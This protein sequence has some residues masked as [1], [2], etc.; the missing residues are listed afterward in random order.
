MASDNATVGTDNIQQ[1][2]G[3]DTLVILNSATVSSDD[4]FNG[5]NGNDTIQLGDTIGGTF[6]LSTASVAAGAGFLSYER[7]KFQVATAPQT[8]IFNSAQFG[9]GRISSSAVFIGNAATT[10]V[11]INMATGDTTFSAAAFTF[12]TWTSGTD[13]FTINGSDGNNTIA[14]TNAVRSIV[15]AGLGNDTITT[16]GSNDSVD[17]G[18]GNDS[19]V[20]AIA[21]GSDSFAGGNG[22][23]TLDYSVVSAALTVT[24]TAIS[25]NGTDVIS[26]F[27]IYKLGSGADTFT[28]GTG[29]ETVDGGGGN[30][31]IKASLGSDSIV[32]GAGTDTLDYSTLG[33]ALTYNVDAGTIAKA[34]GGTDTVSGVESLIFGNAAMNVTGSAGADNL[35]FGSGNDSILAGDGAD[36]INGGDGSDTIDGGTGDDVL[37][38]G[39]QNDY[40]AGKA[41]ADSIDG[42]DG[43]DVIYIGIDS[44]NDTAIGGLGSDT[45]DLRDSTTGVSVSFTAPG[46][47]SVTSGAE[48]DSFTG[49]E[50]YVLT[51]LA[52]TF[53]GSTGNDTV[54]GLAGNDSLDGGDGDDT[55]IVGYGE[56]VDTIVGGNGTDTVKAR[57]AS[58]SVTITGV[59]GVEVF[60]G[61]GFAN[62]RLIG[63][64]GADNIDLTGL[65][66]I[67]VERVDGGAGNDTITGT[68]GNDV[69]ADSAGTDSLLGAD[70]DD[71]FLVN[72]ATGVG[73]AIDGGN[74]T[75]TVKLMSN[76]FLTGTTLT[77]IEAINLNGFA[78]DV[79]DT[80][81]AN[82][83][84]FSG[85]TVS[86]AFA[87]T[88]S[89]GNDTIVGNSGV[90][91]MMGGAGADLLTGGG[92]N[93]VFRYSSWSQSTVAAADHITDFTAGD[94]IKLNEMDANS[95][96]AGIQAWT[97][98]GDTAFTANTP[99]QLRAYFD[100]TNT[101]I[102]G[103]VN[104]DTVAD[105]KLVLD[106]YAGPLTSADFI[107]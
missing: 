35:T 11:V 99:G 70:G 71:T 29:D 90:Q 86:G 54:T 42:G 85:I 32:G 102:E 88:A 41:G 84:D 106:G 40:I 19:I 25:G 14:A 37:N 62:F 13:T 51:A 60:D 7:I 79:R 52:D 1:S 45:L 78:L 12:N 67:N 80:A 96:A 10:N 63:T 81:A 15:N 3:P 104:N 73:D 33:V 83:I 93:D 68:S 65:T 43:N 82:T 50:A 58:T 30:D 75:D 28:G 95:L 36:S 21:D 18:D 66:L 105:F 27:E 48:T 24:A 26:G 9:T 47:G 17:G 72:S 98:I 56:G 74:G 44:S 4:T 69:I 53:V 16:G 107:L 20:A 64:A 55:F 101:I 57:T 34:G 5:G 91:T 49:F 100:G 22:I 23:D 77:S 103:N 97:F 38:G 61:T 94:L 39:A 31:S 76:S 6:D 46:D 92:G 87:I 89:G 2:T 8:V 59:S